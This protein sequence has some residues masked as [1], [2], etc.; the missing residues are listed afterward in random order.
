MEAAIRLGVSPSIFLGRS[1]ASTTTYT[2]RDDGSVL[3]ERTIWDPE[4]TEQDRAWVIAWLTIEK[5]S[6][7][8]CGQ[9]RSMMTK[10]NTKAFDAKTWSCHSCAAIEAKKRDMVE[11]YKDTPSQTDGVFVHSVFNPDHVFKG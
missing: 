3:S 4:Y 7:N 9:P 6:C 2:H 1:K 8:S 5:D 10:E 11:H